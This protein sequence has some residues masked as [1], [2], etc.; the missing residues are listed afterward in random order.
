[1]LTSGAAKIVTEYNSRDNATRVIASL[2]DGAP[3][4]TTA[5]YAVVEHQRDG[6]GAS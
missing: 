6:I 4:D 5:G 3:V 1:M 2:P